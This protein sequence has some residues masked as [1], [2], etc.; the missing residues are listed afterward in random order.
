MICV[1]GY[2]GKGRAYLSR[3][4]SVK[5]RRRSLRKLEVFQKQKSLYLNRNG[6]L[7]Y[8]HQ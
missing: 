3:I 7:L 6:D 8:S 2:S 4:N 5:R 1:K